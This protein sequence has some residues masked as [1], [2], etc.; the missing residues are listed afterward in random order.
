MK[1][2]FIFA[3]TL[4][5]TMNVGAKAVALHAESAWNEIVFTAP[6]STGN[7]AD[8]IFTAPN[9]TFSFSCIDTNASKA[10]TIDA[11]TSIFGTEAENQTYDFRLKPNSNTPYLTLHIPADGILRIAARSANKNDETRTILV[12]QDGANLLTQIIKEADATMV[13][14]TVPYYP[15]YSVRVQPGTVK[16]SAPVGPVNFYSLAFKEE[17]DPDA[18]THF[19]IAGS[20]T[21]WQ[22]G[23]VE[24]KKHGA[25]YTATL[26]LE[27]KTQYQFKVVKVLGTDTT[28]YGVNVAEGASWE[29]MTADN[30]TDW[31]LNGSMNV[32]LQT[33]KAADYT[34]RFVNNE[35]HE[36]SVG[37]P[38]AWDEIVFTDATAA[39]VFNDSLF[40]IPG[41][42]FSMIC[43]NDPQKFYTREQT[44][45]FGT[46]E[47][48]QTYS[49]SFQTG[50]SKNY[51]EFNIPADG[52]FRMAVRSAKA[53]DETRTVYVI[54]DGDTIYARAPKDSEKTNSIYPYYSTYVKQGTIRVSY[55]SVVMFFGFG[56]K[57][58]TLPEQ[59]HF[60]IAGTMT[61]W[62]NGMVEME[63]NGLF[64]TTSLPLEGK[65]QYEFKV[66]K[67]LGTD[68]T[69]YGV[70]VA[71]GASWVPMTADDCTGWWLG[72]G[73][74]IG[75]Q[76]TKKG[77]YTFRFVNNE[78]HEISVEYPS[79]WDEIVFTA[80]TAGGIGAFTDSVFAVKYSD[81]NMTVYDERNVVVIQSANSAYKYGNVA[82]HSE[83][84]YYMNIKSKLTRLI[85]NI[86]EDGVL[87]IAAYKSYLSNYIVEQ[88][89]AII[90]NNQVSS[91]DKSEDGYLPY[92]YVNVQK[93][94]IVIYAQEDPVNFFSFAFNENFDTSHMAID[95]VET[96][97]LGG[98]TK[99][100]RNGQVFIQRGDKLYTVQG[101][102]IK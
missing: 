81:F 86:P 56:F 42:E 68:T 83:Y 5:A 63:Q 55:A 47:E 7:L 97:K 54:Q 43:R 12:E 23:M 22:K 88:N 82:E 31:W 61:D 72:E 35:N 8:S 102:E 95:A 73:M 10:A 40:T 45:T 29:P 26:P 15:Y 38:S 1:K 96:A 44:C 19:Y 92:A 27:A 53:D 52:I 76:T 91:A 66:V 48:H 18:G 24:M 70:N 90:A 13:N 41:S 71:E 25:V 98:S 80:E 14:D 34:F 57:E 64:Y 59:P 30:C 11:N 77:G 17:A 3:A 69:W 94:N 9:S 32:G 74:N 62:Q 49:Y 79:E 39:G 21:E 36:I 89:G 51:L 85:F 99:L 2:L 78:N 58:E 84:M 100:F 65:T 50:G 4:L 33:T 93:G 16:V 37:Y 46:A 67:V 60:Y 87:R 75:L 101:Q 28:W 6:F 20:M